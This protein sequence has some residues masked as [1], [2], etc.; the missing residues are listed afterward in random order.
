MTAMTPTIL[1]NPDENQVTNAVEEFNSLLSN[2]ASIHPVALSRLKSPRQEFSNPF[3]RIESHDDYLFGV[4]ATPTSLLDGEDLY[5][6]LTIIA[7]FEKLIVVVRWSQIDPI[8]IQSRLFLDSILSLPKSF[9][10]CGDFLVL[11]LDKLISDLEDKTKIAHEQIDR[12]LRLLRESGYTLGK[13]FS[14]NMMDELYS[15]A[16]KY[17]IDIMGFQTTVEETQRV[18]EDIAK[19]RVDLKPKDLTSQLEFFP[20]NLEI[21][22]SDL[23]FRVRHL[24]LLRRSLESTLSFSFSK[25]EKMRDELQTSAQHKIAAIASIML[26]PTFIVGLFGQ[27]FRFGTEIEQRWGLTISSVLIVLTTI[28]QYFY[29]KRNKWL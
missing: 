3:P 28:A 11:M 16:S 23:V 4:L 6:T 17:R 12:E 19:D 20:K 2:G 15:S 27:N 13:D 24:V 10:S 14:K 29:F 22:V 26:L 9:S 8:D 25:F 21:E 18:L 7:S 1:I 5:I